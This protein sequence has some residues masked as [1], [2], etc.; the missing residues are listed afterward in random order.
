MKNKLEQKEIF[1]PQQKKQ[2]DRQKR[3]RSTRTSSFYTNSK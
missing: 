3:N 1:D 2:N